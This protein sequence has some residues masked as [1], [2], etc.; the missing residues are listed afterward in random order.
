MF[1]YRDVPRYFEYTSAADCKFPISKQ[2]E[3]HIKR[4]IS[5][6]NNI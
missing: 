3:R 2:V 1:V 5:Q 6:N 4:K